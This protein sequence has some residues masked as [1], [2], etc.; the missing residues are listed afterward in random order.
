MSQDLFEQF[1]KKQPPEEEKIQQYL[2]EGRSTS[3][4]KTHKLDLFKTLAAIDNKDRDY[5]DNLTDE[6]KK[7]FAPFVL[8]RWCSAAQT[9]N[10]LYDY[11]LLVATNERMNVNL[12]N[13][14]SQTTKHPKLQWLMATAT[15][16]YVG[17]LRHEWIPYKKAE[18]RTYAE[19]RKILINMFPHL[20][21]DEIE[22]IIQNT[23]TKDIKE[24][25]KSMGYNDSEIKKI[26]KK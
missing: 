21:D 3:E 8:V 20:N 24:Y 9:N 10:L 6:E 22:L 18:K 13:L 16:P 19:F 7:G 26:S 1:F 5:Y 15:S 25:L 17:K 11:W 14:N 2:A 4:K 12:L 23:T